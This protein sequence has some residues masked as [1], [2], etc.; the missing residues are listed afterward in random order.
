MEQVGHLR[1]LL[2]GD[3]MGV[4]VGGLVVVVGLGP[5]LVVMGLVSFMKVVQWVLIGCF[6]IP[7]MI[8]A[9]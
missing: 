2:A 8:I 4:R 3:D 5:Q 9:S 6:E 1:E 7:L